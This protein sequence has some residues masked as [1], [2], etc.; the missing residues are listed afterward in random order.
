MKMPDCEKATSI[1]T[2]YQYSSLLAILCIDVGIDPKA[3]IA[4]ALP[5]SEMW[6][7]MPW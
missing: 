2:I 6:G 4:A 5:A 1:Y 7:K 3:I